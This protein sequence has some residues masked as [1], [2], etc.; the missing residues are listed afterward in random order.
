MIHTAALLAEY[1]VSSLSLYIRERF[2]VSFLSPSLSLSQSSSADA[3]Q[4]TPSPPALVGK[5]R[6]Q[7]NT[8][9]EQFLCIHTAPVSELRLRTDAE[10]V[11]KVS[12]LLQ[13][14]DLFP[15]LD[16][17]PRVCMNKGSQ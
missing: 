6:L 2:M 12:E 15:R 1:I 4:S 16:W 9:R 11:N 8:Q 3:V 17:S 13:R 7:R 5:G 10:A 14:H